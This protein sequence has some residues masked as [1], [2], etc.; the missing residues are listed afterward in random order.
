[1]KIEETTIRK[2]F[3]VE[4]KGRR[5]HVDFLNSEGP[6]QNML[7]PDR[8]CFDIRRVEDYDEEVDELTEESG[9]W[10]DDDV[11]DS[12]TKRQLIRHVIQHFNDKDKRLTEIEFQEYE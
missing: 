8:G 12:A 10:A 2:T 11:I 5:Y 4:H 9:E 7:E 6:M 1:M 3:Q